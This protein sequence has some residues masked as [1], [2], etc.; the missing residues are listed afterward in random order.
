MAKKQ[1]KAFI[2]YVGPF[3]GGLPGSEEEVRGKHARSAKGARS[4]TPKVG[5]VAGPPAAK[6]SIATGP[7][8]TKSHRA[9]LD[10]EAAI[11]AQALEDLERDARGTWAPSGDG[12]DGEGAYDDVYAA[13]AEGYG[14]DGYGY[15]DGYDGNGAPY[16]D[17][18]AAGYDV[19]EWGNPLGT[20]YDDYGNAYLPL[21]EWG[22]PVGT[23]YDEYGNAYLPGEGYGD[24]YDPLLDPDYDPLAASSAKQK[25]KGLFGRH[26]EA[27]QAPEPAFT[28]MTLEEKLDAEAAARARSEAVVSAY[29]SG[30]PLGLA[31][32]LGT[33]GFDENYGY[34][35]YDDG[36]DLG[37]AAGYDSWAEG[38]GY[39]YDGFAG[40]GD[41]AAAGKQGKGGAAAA[42]GAALGA[43]AALPMAAASAVSGRKGGFSGG[44]GGHGGVGVQVQIPTASMEKSLNLSASRAHQKQ[45]DAGT[46]S[47]LA[48]TMKARGAGVR[49]A[50]NT[51]GAD[52]ELGK[53]FRRRV[54][55]I[56][57]VLAIVAV[58]AGAGGAVGYFMSLS[59]RLSLD[60]IEA[61]EAALTEPEENEPYY[62]LFTADLND[63]D[64]SNDDFDAGFIA[65]IDEANRR[66]TILAIPGNVEVIL[67]DFKYHPATE[68]RADGGNARLIT[69]LSDLLDL[70]IAH[71]VST[72]AKGLVRIIDALG[73]I[74]MT[75][76]QD[77]DDPQAGWQ[78]MPA[79]DYHLTGEEA[80]V[81]LRADNFH[82]GEQ[83]RGENRCTFAKLMM[84]K[85]LT[86]GFLSFANITDVIA[87]SVDT[88][89]TAREI[90]TLAKKMSGLT[91]A[92]VY[93][94]VMPG[95]QETTVEGYRVFSP[96]Y[97][98]LKAMVTLMDAGLSPVVESQH[99]ANVNPAD[100]TVTVWNGSG[101][102]G[103]AALLADILTEAGFIV[104]EVTN[105]KAFV[106][107]ET[108]IIYDDPDNLEPAYAVQA[109]LGQGRVLDGTWKYTF[110]TDI[111]VVL[112]S[113]WK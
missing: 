75:L 20:T 111:L 40:D 76:A 5:M 95:D 67:S 15:G 92:D 112:G 66:V 47:K 43:L 21:D 82:E 18:A 103:G 31:D 79:G 9:A 13:T 53:I 8:V 102:T 4:A 14:Y 44:S 17:Y 55:T 10:A 105:A 25:L 41:A 33:Y 39:D 51:Y 54:F 60:D 98:Q 93:S 106:Y 113:E 89:F 81:V 78:Y 59:N 70:K 57:I 100:V 97:S 83:T 62:I 42:A 80:L 19:D 49:G 65:R 6:S 22:N 72:D 73:G 68:A 77:I 86:S 45:V 101:V 108:L 34:D 32:P 11:Q 7:L 50:R 28:G 99:G 12:W 27:Q 96:S 24:G 91:A 88:D 63:M 3:D 26:R 94:G 84:E 61:V 52:K 69:A 36:F 48:S 23:T 56:L 71:I 58:A 16:F 90:L 104:K 46:G 109:A 110:G 87:G 35:G 38:D 37:D 1:N 2:D 29:E 107:T 30:V 74:D 85:I 64:G